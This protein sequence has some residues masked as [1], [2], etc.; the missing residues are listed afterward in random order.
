[1]KRKN[2]DSRGQIGL[3]VSGDHLTTRMDLWTGPTGEEKLMRGARSSLLTFLSV[4]VSDAHQFL[5]CSLSSE[6]EESEKMSSSRSS[7]ILCFSSVN[8]ARVLFKLS[9]KCEL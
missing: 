4:I 7:F 3:T 2:K 8:S 6:A 1:M 5:L 9:W